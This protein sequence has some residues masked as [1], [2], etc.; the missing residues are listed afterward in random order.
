VILAARGTLLAFLGAADEPAALTKTDLTSA[1][2]S[3]ST[4]AALAALPTLPVLS[5]VA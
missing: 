3:L 4:L 1:T 2:S 5:L